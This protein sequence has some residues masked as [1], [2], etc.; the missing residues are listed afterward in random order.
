MT[1]AV[2]DK[3]KTALSIKFDLDSVILTE[4]FSI[5]QLLLLICGQLTKV[6][7]MLEN[8]DFTS[9]IAPIFFN[10]TLEYLEVN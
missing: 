3:E 1:N 4:K 5:N 6:I 2:P 7:Q 10:S 9:D 8:T